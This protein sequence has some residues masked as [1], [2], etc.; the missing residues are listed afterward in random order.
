MSRGELERGER[1]ERE[2]PRG[3]GHVLLVRVLHE[4]TEAPGERRAAGLISQGNPLTPPPAA[5]TPVREEEYAR[6]KDAPTPVGS[7]QVG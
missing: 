2:D 6:V 1:N 4:Q 5:N 7:I 3:I